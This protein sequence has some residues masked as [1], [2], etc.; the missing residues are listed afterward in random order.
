MARTIA[1]VLAVV[2]KVNL[3]GHTFRVGH[4]TDPQGKHVDVWFIQD[5]YVRPDA[6]TQEEG[7]GFGRKWHV[8]PHATDSEIILTC[9]KAAITNAEHE[10]REAFEYEG[11]RIFQPHIDV[12]ALWEACE[13]SDARTPPAQ[14]DQTL[15]EF[16]G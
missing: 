8:S 13:Q 12:D 15:A 6:L 5:T 2:N 3:P 14:D 7:T 9:L 4:L 1:G 10:V 16:L 11:R